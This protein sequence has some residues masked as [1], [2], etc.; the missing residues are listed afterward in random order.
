MA[1]AGQQAGIEFRGEGIIAPQNGENHLFTVIL[2]IGSASEGSFSSHDGLFGGR[3]RRG[4]KIRL[5][6]ARLRVSPHNFGLRA[7]IL[8]PLFVAHVSFSLVDP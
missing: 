5:G 2:A 7:S 6:F 4:R 3:H 8:P 1:D